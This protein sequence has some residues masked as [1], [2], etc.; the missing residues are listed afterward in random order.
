MLKMAKLSWI[1]AATSAC[2]LLAATTAA[3]RAA[4]D[5][6]GIDAQ[7][8]PQSP[9]MLVGEWV[10]KDPQQI[11]FASL[12]RVTSQHAV[13]SDVRGLHG[14]NQHAYKL[15]QDSVFPLRKSASITRMLSTASSMGVG[16]AVSSRIARV[17]KAA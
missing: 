1:L 15:S 10:P 16:T 5:T 17:N 8:A 11:D 13:V 7:N 12:P 14:V 9:P 2:L 6:L 4:E 3:D